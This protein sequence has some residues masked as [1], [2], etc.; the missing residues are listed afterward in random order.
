M[1]FGFSPSL[2]QFYTS[3]RDN[4]TF[5]VVHCKEEIVV[6]FFIRN[7]VLIFTLLSLVNQDE[8]PNV[9]DLLV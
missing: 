8:L 4:C 7:A 3:F 2:F 6:N 5:S 1:S 9:S